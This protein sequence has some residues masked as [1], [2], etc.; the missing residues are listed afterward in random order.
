MGRL[1]IRISCA[2]PVRML[3]LAQH[4]DVDTRSWH[5][6]PI[7]V[8][9]IGRSGVGREEYIRFLTEWQ[10]DFD[11]DLRKITG[12]A[13][14][15]RLYFNQSGYRSS[16]NCRLA[17]TSRQSPSSWHQS[18]TRCFGSQALHTVALGSVDDS[19]GHYKASGF[20]HNGL[21][22]GAAIFDGEFGYNQR[23]LECLDWWWTSTTTIRLKYNMPIALET[24][25]SVIK[26]SDL[27]AG[28][29]VDFIDGTGSPP[30]VTGI[31]IASSIYLDDV[32]R[33]ADWQQASPLHCR[34]RHK[35]RRGPRRHGLANRKPIRHP[36]RNIL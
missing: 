23:S 34:A 12:Q 35:W 32:V 7:T 24:D 21:L 16:I 11:H 3:R 18:G 10:Q 2:L 28:K 31:A 13:K 19:G 4:P 8:R 20:Y 26:I 17:E 6:P 33:S 22:L 5:S 15:I 29:G 30:T 1:G 36:C 27:G 9:L 25:D 14:P